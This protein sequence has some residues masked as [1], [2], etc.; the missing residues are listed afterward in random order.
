MPN[1]P[2]LLGA[3]ASGLYANKFANAEHKQF[4]ESIMRSIGVTIWV[5]TEEQM[6]TVTALSGSG[7]AYFLLIF[8]ALIKAAQAQGL[9]EEQAKLLTL[10]TA[11][12]AA[13]MAMESKDSIS[14]LRRKVTSPGGTT[15]YALNILKQ[16]NLETTF[17]R[18]LSAAK[19]RAEEMSGIFAAGENKAIEKK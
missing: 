12:G 16:N 3:G 13:R 17:A 6:D 8:E 19:D 1:T 7:P 5:E 15:E 11:L 14:E 2:S 9:E 18:A 4:A 10:Q